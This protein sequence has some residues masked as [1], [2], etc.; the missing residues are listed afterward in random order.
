MDQICVD[1]ECVDIGICQSECS[2][3]GLKECF[4]NGYKTCKDT[5]GDGCLEWSSVTSCGTG[6][7]CSG[8]NCIDD[9]RDRTQAAE[10]VGA[11]RVIYE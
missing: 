4:G 5:N 2:T 11:L 6:K 7:V 8:G 9:I 3:N 10:E 1:K